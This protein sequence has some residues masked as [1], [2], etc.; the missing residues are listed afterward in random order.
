MSL[1]FF[2]SATRRQDDDG[3]H[4]DLEVPDAF[5]PGLPFTAHSLHPTVQS[6]EL[7]LVDALALCRAVLIDR[8]G[9]NFTLEPATAARDR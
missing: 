1:R 3:H 6:A 9:S 8:F 2:Y 7:A 5:L 4:L